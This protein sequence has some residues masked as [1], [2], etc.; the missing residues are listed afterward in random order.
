M[1]KPIRPYQ[2]T[3]AMHMTTIRELFFS[4]VLALI[5]RIS[6]QPIMGGKAPAAPPITMFCG[7]ERLSHMVPSTATENSDKT[8]PNENASEAI[9]RPSG[10]G[11]F[12]VRSITA[13]MSASYHMFRAPDAPAPIEMHNIATNPKN[14]LM[15]PGC[16]QHANDSALQNT[17]RRLFISD[18]RLIIL[19]LAKF[20]TGGMEAVKE[21]ATQ[22]WLQP[23][24]QGLSPAVRFFLNASNTR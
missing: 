6:A 12:A 3:M 4:V 19:P 5:E 18:L 23:S 24:P 17:S 13:S 10:I 16:H 9:T 15:L 2:R 1:H 7:V 21:V 11:R 14:G 8:I 20:P 22:V